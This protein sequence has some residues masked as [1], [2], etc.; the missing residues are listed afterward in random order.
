[1]SLGVSIEVSNSHTIP[2]ISLSL[3]MAV[4]H[5]V[6]S[7]LLLQH[8]ICLPPDMIAHFDGDGL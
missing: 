6:S 4:S 7:Q 2:S 8:C 5:G 1:M 3:L